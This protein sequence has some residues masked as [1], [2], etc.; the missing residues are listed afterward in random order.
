MKIRT[1]QMAVFEEAARRSF[2]EEMVKHSKDFAPELSKVIGDDQLRVAIRAA[3]MRAD[4]YGFTNRGPIRLFIELM[5]LC[6]SGFDTDPQY[7]ALG[8]ALR[9]SE[10]QML[11]ADK[12]YEGCLDYLDNVAGPGASNVHQALRDLL[13]FAKEPV[14]FSSNVFVASMLQEMRRLFPRKTDYV[15]E[16]NLETLINEGLAEAERYGFSDV[17]PQTLIV[18][19][20]FAFGHGCTD[21]PLYPWI[22]RTL[23]DKRITDAE[24][25][26]ARLEKKAI[27][28]LEHVVASLPE[29]VQT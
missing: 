4:S 25:R 19:L 2:D 23:K 29:G 21:D 28:W 11:R 18:V 22:S 9:A 13:V 24:A 20:M 7:P 8:N 15:G 26:A 14:T 6:G 10:D 5:F 16:K 1:E 12:I 17:R 27:T 3:M